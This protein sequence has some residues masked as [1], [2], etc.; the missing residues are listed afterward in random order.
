MRL[1][2]KEWAI[3]KKVSIHDPNKQK[4]WETVIVK[5][6]IAIMVK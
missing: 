3:I 4:Q 6:I 2:Y 1:E 5:I